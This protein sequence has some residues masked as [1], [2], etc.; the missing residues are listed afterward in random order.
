MTEEIRTRFAPSPTGSLHLGGVRTAFF[1]W[2]FAR[3][4]NGKFILRI[5]D[6]DAER[7][8]EES[9]KGIIESMKWLGLD[10]DE[11]PFFQSER[12]DIYNQH[13]NKLREEGKI[14][15]AFDTMEE[16]EAMREKAREAKQNP[17][18]DRRA[19][20]LSTA[21]IEAK[22]KAGEPFVWR[23]KVDMDEYTDIPELLMGNEKDH[24]IKNSTFG[25][26]IITRPGTLENPGMPLYNFACVIDDALMR[27]SHVFRGME[28]LP[29]TP[30]QVL[31]YK[32]FGY[33]VP[34]FIHMPIIMKNGKKMSKRDPDYDPNFPVSILERRDLGYLPEATLNFLALLGWSHPESQELLTVEEILKDFSTDRLNKANANFDEGKY[35]HINGWHLKNYPNEKLVDM[36]TPFLE[37]AGYDVNMYNR[38]NLCRMMEMEKERCHLLNQFPDALYFFFNEPT[39]YEE[40]GIKKSFM[41]ENAD[42]ILKMTIDMLNGL[43]ENEKDKQTL[44]VKLAEMVAASG[45]KYGIVGPII[46]LAITGRTVSPGLADILE[47]IG[48]EKACIRL[49]KAREWIKALPPLSL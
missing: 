48:T 24:K 20:E 23:F 41:N 9:A 39:E 19:L 40:K 14:Y 32:A 26:F 1:N 10:W 8:T 29:N 36:V 47:V 17:I 49:Q 16:L 46:R 7:S 38:T 2:L 4:N 22:M 42:N 37:K 21:E 13:L 43:S 12:L 27:I 28:H 33:E 45:I 6:T 31:L 44:D 25:D 34:K 15:P 11:G 35:A 18:Y 5:E 30:K 3:Q